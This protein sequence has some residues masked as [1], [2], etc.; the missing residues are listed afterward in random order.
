VLAASALFA[1]HHS[2]RAASDDVRLTRVAEFSAPDYVAA[3]PGVRD[4]LYVVERAG[5][6]IAYRHGRK[7]TFLN[8]TQ[9]TG[10]DGEQGLL[11]IAFD[12]DYR[13]NQLFYT[14]S[15]NPDG[16]IE[17]DRF[18]AHSDFA[19][20]E[21]SRHPV[22]VIPHP[23]GDFHYGG[24]I[25]FGSDGLLY[26]GTGDGAISFNGARTDTLLGKLLRIDP[27]PE[28]GSGYSVPSSNP[29]VGRPGADEIY[30]YG[31][32]NP[33]RF[34]FDRPT[35]DILIGEVGFNSWEEIDFVSAKRLRGANFGWDYFE[36]RHHTISDG[37]PEPGRNYRPPIL[38]YAHS[39]GRCA[40]IGGVRVRANQ[41]GSLVGRY[42]Y[43]DLCTGQLR[44]LVPHAQRAADDRSLG[45]AV[46]Q[47]SAITSV[48][49]QVYV[50]SLDGPVY[51]LVEQR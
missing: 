38:E 42:L 51:R 5:K 1:G 4:T 34:S 36:G 18:R 12:P 32:R 17:I 3:A 9:R 10:T 28:D 6:V 33:F 50:T 44:S 48:N 39:N 14:Y 29:F 47:P 11:S 24:T 25:E 43:A 2:A 37:S 46:S 26:V 40:I 23:N 22:L 31:L 7:R 27:D 35:G 30:A 19:A 45:L 13:R 15:A 21:K 20:S 16:D 8:M 41:L 49:G